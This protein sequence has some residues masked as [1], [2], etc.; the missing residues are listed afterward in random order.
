MSTTAVTDWDRDAALTTARILLEIKAINFRPAEPYTFTSGWKSPVY[1]DCRRIIYFPR[2]RAKVGKLVGEGVDL[3][4]FHDWLFCR[5]YAIILPRKAESGSPARP[6]AGNSALM[7][8]SLTEPDTCHLAA[9]SSSC[10]LQ[11]LQWR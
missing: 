11:R 8:R 2:A 4:G 10:S 3:F 6:N 5:N 9:T 7:K 1:I